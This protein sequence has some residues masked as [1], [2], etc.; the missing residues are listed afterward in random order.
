M[1]Y[2]Y[3]ICH[4][5]KEEIEY[6]STALDE[7]G[8]LEIAMNYVW[9]E[10]LDILEDLP[11]D[12]IFYSPS[13]DFTN[14]VSKHSFCLTAMRDKNNQLEFSLWYNRKV[15]YKVLFGLLGKK[16]KMQVV[17]KWGFSKKDALEYL[18]VFLDKEYKEL[19]ALMTI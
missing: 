17:D 10:K 4:P 16:E 6:P 5:E 13:I 19:E 8:V 9:D 11:E 12:D 15:K 1:S 2:T 3:S 14:T 7:K 18:K